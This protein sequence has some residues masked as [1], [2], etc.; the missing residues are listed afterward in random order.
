M[1]FSMWLWGPQSLL[2]S[3]MAAVSTVNYTVLVSISHVRIH[4]NDA[5]LLRDDA[6]IFTTFQY[7]LAPIPGGLASATVGVCTV[8]A[9]LAQF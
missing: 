1:V 5:V 8:I 7:W 9:A 6:K 3:Y 2:M 4:G